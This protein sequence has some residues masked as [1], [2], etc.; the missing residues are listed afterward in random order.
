VQLEPP[1]AA[2]RGFGLPRRSGLTCG[3]RAG[4]DLT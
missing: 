3:A 2:R 4:H 1:D